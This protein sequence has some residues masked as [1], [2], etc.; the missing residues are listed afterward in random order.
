MNPR[1]I[2]HFGHDTI[3]GV[4]LS[5]QMAFPNASNGRIAREFADSVKALCHKGGASASASC[6]GGGV[7]AGV[8][9][10]ND[11]DVKGR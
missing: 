9:A 6:G 5:Y 1:F 3:E 11:N 2:R 8:A 10:A 4:N 7:A